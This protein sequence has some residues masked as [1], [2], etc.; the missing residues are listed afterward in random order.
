MERQKELYR[1][2]KTKTLGSNHLPLPSKAADVM[3]YP[4]DW[5]DIAG[6]HE[7][8]TKVY[9][10][11]MELGIRVRWGGNFKTFYDAPHWEIIED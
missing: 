3:P 7:F 10:K 5:E 9:A 1:E 11:A 8:A 2:G 4:I 6:Q